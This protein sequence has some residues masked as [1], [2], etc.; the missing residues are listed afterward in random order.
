MKDVKGDKVKKKS[1]AEEAA[2]SFDEAVEE[3]NEQEEMEKRDFS[4]LTKQVQSEYDKAWWHIKPK[5]DEWALRIKLFSNQKRDKEA[6][7]DNTLFTI[8]QTVFSSLY[9]DTLVSQFEGRELGDEEAA[10]NLTNLA[11]YDFDEMEK[12]VVDYEWDWE[13]LFF[14]RGLVALME[15]DREKKCPMPEVW[16]VMSV[17]R[18]PEA[19]SVNGDAKGRGRARYL[20]R[21]VR[22]TKLEMKNAGVYFNLDKLEEDGYSTHSLVDEQMRI[23]ADAQGLSQNTKFNNVTGENKSYRLVQWFTVYGGKRCFV[24]LAN[25]M[26]TVVRY[27]EMETMDI[28]I[29]DRS[30]YPMPN[31][32][33]GVSVPDL[34]EDKQRAKAVITNL[35]L[36][37]VKSSMHPMYMYDAT[38]IKNRND[39]NFEFNKFVA[40]QGNPTGAV[41]VMPKDSVKQDASYIL[42]IISR[43]AESSTATPDTKQGVRPDGA[44]TA[45]RDALISQG[46]DTRYSLSAKV[47][48]W[49][50]KR[51]WKQWYRLYKEHFMAGIDEKTLRISGALG[52][53]WRPITK[54]NITLKS[55]PDV[56]V[57]SKAITEAKRAAQLQK[58]Q[59]MFQFAAADPNANLR[60]GVRYMATLSGLSK[61]VVDR[62]LPPTVE[63]MRA[64][65]ENKIMRENPDEVVPVL[66]TDDHLAHIEIHNKMED[67]PAKIAH[68]NAHKKAMMLQKMKPEIFGQGQQE[69]NSGVKD[70]NIAPAQAINAQSA[71]GENKGTQLNLANNA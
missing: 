21:E 27:V 7:G 44:D 62:F 67:T 35:G 14:G 11:K 33:D 46:S 51:F 20:G 56:K 3:F 52:A 12:D 64:E 31:S 8:F 34:I 53:K 1:R 25:D 9:S 47:F 54:E 57:E 48:G 2:E 42:D 59:T 63:E 45:T 15:F 13:S 38:R 10:E 41:Q 50:E 55:D 26:K 32:W 70:E 43:G 66:P 5:W 71:I 60:F 4:N 69:E 49:S 17:L 40:V 19:K 36:K 58:F 18:D 39:L 16:N 61:D 22:M 24:T 37:G 28:P 65:E 30:I 68:I 23:T 29:I 6:V